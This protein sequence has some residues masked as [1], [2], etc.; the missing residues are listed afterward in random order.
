M[1]SANGIVTA[2]GGALSH[3]AVVSRALDKPCI[4]GCEL[5]AIDPAART[6]TI[7]G[8]VFHEGDEISIDGASGQVYPGSIRLRT[9][10]SGRAPLD[11][12]LTL[13]DGNRS[14]RSGSRREMRL[15][16]GN[17]KR[18]LPGLGVARLTDLVIS[19]GGHRG[20]RATDR[21]AWPERHGPRRKPKSPG[22][23]AKPATRCSRRFGRPYPVRLSRISSDRARR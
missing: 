8:E 22:S 2:T 11:R 17:W 13:A 20:V 19:Q 1:L 10:G 12:L 3:A 14:V 4:V 23:S 7:A 6:F 5:I 21:A 9:G 15:M 18:P 16:R